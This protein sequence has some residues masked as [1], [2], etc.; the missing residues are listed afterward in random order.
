[1]NVY[2]NIVSYFVLQYL[3]LDHIWWYWIPNFDSCWFHLV[4]LEFC[5]W[6][7][8]TLFNP[9]KMQH[10]S[11]I[12]LKTNSIQFQTCPW[13]HFAFCG[14]GT[15]V[16][17]IWI[18]IDVPPGCSLY[19]MQ[20]VYQPSPLCVMHSSKSKR[21]SFHTRTCIAYSNK[22]HTK[23]W[24]RCRFEGLHGQYMAIYIYI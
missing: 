1:M 4:Y 11:S 5:F 10:P 18:F 16:L 23:S 9:Y 17:Y 20:V 15:S 7:P 19:K 21:T 22:C 6:A 8:T 2:D 13:Q 14:Q 3:L 12:Y 24:P